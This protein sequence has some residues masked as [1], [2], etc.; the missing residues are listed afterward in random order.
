MSSFFR[1]NSKPFFIYL[2]VVLL[3]LMAHYGGIIWLEEFYGAL[4]V[5]AAVALAFFALWGYMEYSRQEESVAISFLVANEKKKTGLSL[6][7]KNCTRSEL[8]GVLGMIQKDPKTRFEIA[9]MKKAAFLDTL[10]RIQKE[11]DTNLYITLTESE[12]K[13]FEV[14]Q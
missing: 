4:D 10:A 6:L 13:Q 14:E 5:A 11:S 9:S 1:V 12:L 7:R 8:L 2:T 3:G